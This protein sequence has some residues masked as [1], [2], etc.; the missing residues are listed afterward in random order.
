MKRLF[1]AVLAAALLPGAA[2]AAKVCAAGATVPGIDVSK[3]QGTINWSNV[4]ASGQKFVIARVSDGINT[5]DSKFA[6]YWPAMKQAGFVVGV[7]QFFR[8][9]QDPIAQADLLLDMMGPME[10]GMLPPTLDVEAADGQ[11]KA[12]VE[13]AIAQWI[14]HVQ[15]KLGVA[16]LIYTS[17]YFWSNSVGSSAQAALPL[18]VANWGVSC[19]TLPSVWNDWKIWQT[20]ETGSV[21]GI[22]GNCDTDEFNGD[23]EALQAYTSGGGVAPCTSINDTLTTAKAITSGTPYSGTACAAGDIDYFSLSGCGAFAGTVTANASSFDCSCAILDSKGSELIEGGAEGYVRND[24]YAGGCACSITKGS[25]SYYLKIFAEAAGAYTFAKTAPGA[26]T[27]AG[28]CAACPSGDECIAGASCRGW[29]GTSITF[30]AL[31]CASAS[32]PGGTTCTKESDGSWCIPTV[33]SA[34][35]GSDVWY[36]DGCGNWISQKIACGGGASCKAGACVAA[37]VCGNGKCDGFETS[38]TCPADCG[39]PP[40][41]CGDGACALSETCATCPQDCSCG[42]GLLCV[43]GVCQ[44]APGCGNSICDT[45]ESPLSCCQD[46]GCPAGKQCNMGTCKTLVQC[47]DNICSPGEAATC[48]WDCACGEG[49][50][51]TNAGCIA[52]CGDGFC[53]ASESCESCADDCTCLGPDAQGGPDIVGVKPDVVSV[54]IDVAKGSDAAVKDSAVSD[55][56]F[57]LPDASTAVTGS[58]GGGPASGC[59]TSRNASGWWQLAALLGLAAVLRRARRSAA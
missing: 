40:K 47:G 59:S 49:L 50:T 35:N 37:T 39:A 29:S 36:K 5:P 13:A 28:S 54:P 45:G 19:P 18:W 38:S 8:P 10:P 4:K 7:Y 56:S 9:S 30:C 16:P 23:L 46:C 3:W 43:N 53:H 12:Q 20:A 33:G 48:C 52:E 31:S 41:P 34:C 42:G 32:C 17:S 1:A 26:C 21:S 22:S 24:T 15:A 2:Y 51:C 57:A 25:G 6:S 44:V 11:S 55:L 27:G 14:A 58:G